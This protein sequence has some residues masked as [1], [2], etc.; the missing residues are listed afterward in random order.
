[1]LQDLPGD[2]GIL[3]HRDEA[4]RPLAARAG[5]R[6]EPE[7]AREQRRPVEPARAS[8]VIGQTGERAGGAGGGERA[9]RAGDTG[10]GYT[11]DGGATFPLRGRGVGRIPSFDQ[12]LSAFPERS[13]LIHLK[14]N[15]PRAGDR[16]VDRLGVLSPAARARIMAYGA[17]RPLAKIAARIPELRSLDKEQAKAC[18]VRYL[19]LGWTGHVPG[20]CRNTVV[21]VPIERARWL[22]GWPRRF[23]ARM[24]SVGTEV[25]LLR[26]GGGGR[27]GGFDDAAARARIPDDFGGLVWTDRIEVVA[28]AP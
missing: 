17:P 5:Q 2:G 19:T 23:E 14:T 26:Q 22:W 24:R 20:P 21:A 3:D 25:I 16:V 7:R 1:M 18:L 6:L 10:F 15:D 28:S 9:E 12:V 8:R 13:F 11:A 27:L 4:H